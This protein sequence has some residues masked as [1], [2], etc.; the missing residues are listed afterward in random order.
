MIPHHRCF[1]RMSW[2]MLCIVSGQPIERF[3]HLKIGEIEGAIPLSST[4]SLFLFLHL[5]IINVY[6]FVWFHFKV[7]RGKGPSLVI[8]G[9]NISVLPPYL[10]PAVISAVSPPPH[11]KQLLTFEWICSPQA[12]S[13]W[14]FNPSILTTAFVFSTTS[15]FMCA[16]THTHTHTHTPV[17]F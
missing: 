7:H 11:A 1:I 4:N 14:G 13:L 6:L 15:I 5:V 9:G 2:N 12:P 8:L 10:F 3:C 16:C 17:Y